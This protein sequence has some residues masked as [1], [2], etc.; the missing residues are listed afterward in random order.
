MT[1]IAIA[2]ALSGT[3]ATFNLKPSLSP[4]RSSL[5]YLVSEVPRW[6]NENG[7][8]SCHHNGD[9]VRVLYRA[10]SLGSDVSL[11]ALSGSTAWLSEPDRWGQNGGDGGFSDRRLARI[12]FAS[13][14]VQATAA[15]VLSDPA[16]LSRAAELLADDQEWDG[17]WRIDGPDVIGSPTTYGWSLSTLTAR[18]VLKA[19]DPHRYADRIKSADTWLRNR[20]IRSVMDAS[21]ELL[22]TDQ[23]TEATDR[24]RLAIERLQQGEGPEGGWG[25]Y[26]TSP[27][28]PFDTALGIL[29]LVAE[30]STEVIPLVRRGR[31]ALLAQQLPSGG[32]AETTRP[33][34]GV[35]DAQHLSTTAWA[36]L[37]LLESRR[38]LERNNVGQLDQKAQPDSDHANR[39]GTT[40]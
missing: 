3:P 34:G 26:V 22:R 36:T 20:P 7:C 40:P 14:L 39:S 1:W 30:G 37:G 23:S 31:S 18:N 29:G 17:S 38:F 4:E 12:Q 33:A 9:G 25:P 8:A 11:N 5:A 15:G 32:W 16:P 35:S 27:P 19:V 2:V 13:A 21:V 6:Q 28:E 24:R 10:R